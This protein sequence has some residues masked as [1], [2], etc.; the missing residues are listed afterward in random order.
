[1]LWLDRMSQ[2][3]A[4]ES[5][6]HLRGPVLSLAIHSV[7]GIAI[8]LVGGNRVVRRAAPET[9]R[10]I[11]LIAPYFADAGHGGG[12]GGDRSLLPATRGRLPKAESRQFTP[13]VA[14][15][16]NFE[17]KLLLDPALILKPD[18]APPPVNVTDLG[19]PFG[20]LGPKSN[21][22]GSGG[23]IGVGRNGGVGPGSGP[24]TGPGSGG[25][26]GGGPVSGRFLGD[27]G[28]PPVLIY[29]V[30]PEF[31]E[32]A[33]QAK[34]QGVV[35]L[36]GEVDTTGRLTNVRILHGLGLGLD[37]KAIAAVRRWRFRPGYREG[38]P[39]ITTATIEVN[40]HLL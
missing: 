21:G 16:A 31:S 29:K 37:E 34:Y 15:T 13:P 36:V 2:S 14:V 24:G 4:F 35:I 17:P 20:G 8:F 1:M 27:G 40:F 30:E 5:R 38:K 12:G 32:E 23:G 9:A 11:R 25:E 18:L 7:C 3:D 39:I 33:R 22:P 6:S 28:T 19:D 10:C 26:R